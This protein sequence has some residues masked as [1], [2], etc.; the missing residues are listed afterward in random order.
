MITL[1]FNRFSRATRV[2]WMLEELGVPYDLVR[3]DMAKGEH[4]APSYLEIHPLGKLPAIVVDGKPMIESLAIIQFLALKF[5]EKGLGPTPENAPD[6]YSWMV[7]AQ[8]TL[9]P[10]VGNYF[11]SS[12]ERFGRMDAAVAEKAKNELRRLVVPVEKQLS[13]NDYIAGSQ[14]TAADVVMGGVLAWAGTMGLLE[15]FPAINAY[16]GRIAA[17]PAFRTGRA[18]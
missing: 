1:Y 17:R 5:P 4:K 7:Y 2:R 6:Y 14:F 8:V 16:I 18:E 13:R 3:V 11:Y 12:N 10:E 15:G 9:E